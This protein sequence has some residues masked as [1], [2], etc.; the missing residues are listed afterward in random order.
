M[1]IDYC[2][3]V[4]NE[5]SLKSKDETINKCI[6]YIFTNYREKITVQMIAKKIGI[7]P[8]YLS[9]KF[10]KVTGINLPSFINQKNTRG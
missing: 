3:R 9:S 7:S 4:Q 8:E 5:K 6:N 1:I 10:K 2:T